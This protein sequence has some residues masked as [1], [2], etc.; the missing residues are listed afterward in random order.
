M[1]ITITKHTAGKGD[2]QFTVYDTKVFGSTVRASK[3]L[4]EELAK[5]KP[6]AIN[7]TTAEYDLP[8]DIAKRLIL[9]ATVKNGFTNLYLT[10]K[11]EE[12]KT[13]EKEDEALPF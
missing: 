3:T 7:G 1:K 12:A 6:G 13:T 9:T 10:L 11:K 4:I 8:D 5:L 2:K